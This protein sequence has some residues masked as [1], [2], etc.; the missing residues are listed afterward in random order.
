MQEHIEQA[1]NLIANAQRVVVLTGAGISTP[2]GVPDFRSDQGIWQHYDPFEIA[3]VASFRRDPLRF[4]AWFRPLLQRMLAAQPNPAHQALAHLEQRGRLQAVITQNI[5]GLHQAAGSREVFELHGHLRTAT[6]LGCETQ[7]A[8]TKLLPAIEKGKLLRCTCGDT[9]KPDVVLFDELLPRGM[10]WL[11]QRAMDSADLIV[12]A[13]TSLEV[14]PV[15]EMP[16]TAL[17]RGAKLVIMNRGTTY[18]DEY[19]SVCI[20]ADL[21]EALPA[22]AASEA[23]K[24]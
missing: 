21:A 14:S 11:A 6:C 23:L 16:L 13:G 20:N 24:H 1:S 4:F 19:A 2:S 17:R 8:A 18:L 9:Y 12:I 22:V 10:F 3:S 7:I 5:D 15:C